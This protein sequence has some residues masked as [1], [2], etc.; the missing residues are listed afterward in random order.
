MNKYNIH[1]NNKHVEKRILLVDNDKNFTESLYDILELH[2]YTLEVAY[3]ITDA[4]KIVKNFNAH[5]ALLDL[6]MPDWPGTTLLSKLMKENQERICII[7]TGNADVDSA[8]SAMK[9]D[10]FYYLQK[11]VQP[12]ALINLL[13]RAFEK[14]RFQDEKRLTGISLQ[15]ES[16]ECFRL[17]FENAL[18]AI[19]WTDVTTDLII[20][21][22]IAAESLLEKEK[23]NIVGYHQSLVFPPEKAEYYLD[24]FKRQLEEKGI[25]DSETEVITQ[26]GKRKPVRI[27]AST[28]RIGKR[29]IIQSIIRDITERK[30]AESELRESEIKYRRLIEGLQ[31]NYFF[32]AYNSEGIFTYISPSVKNVLGYSPEEFLTHY[33]KYLTDNPLNNAMKRHTE[34]CLKGVKQPPY[35]AE[36][37]HKNG[38]LRILQAQDIPIFDTKNI[39]VEVKGIAKDITMQKLTEKVLV[40][41]ARDAVLIAEVGVAL[42]SNNTLQKTLQTCC[43]SIVKNLDAAFTRIWTFNENKH[44][45]ELQ[46]SSGMYTHIDGFHSSVPVGNLM[47]GLIAENRQPILTNSVTSDVRIKDK[48]WAKREGI[49]SF[50]GYPLL[51]DDRLMGVLALFSRNYLQKTILNTLGSIAVGIALGMK[52]IRTEDSLKTRIEF[53]GMVSRISTR[54]VKFSDF[55]KAINVSLSDVGKLCNASRV[56]LFRLLENGKY[57]DNTHEWCNA[58]VAP[59]TKY[60]KNIPSSS[61]PWLLK[62]LYAGKTIHIPDVSKIS[63]EA[64]VEKE[65][66]MKKGIKSLLIFPVYTGKELFGFIGFDSLEINIAWDEEDI[67]LLRIT[68]E[69]I[70]SAI[71]RNQNE[72][73]LRKLSQAVEQSPSTTIITDTTGTIEYVNKKFSES[74][75]Y[76]YEEVVGK[77]PRILK[78][79]NMPLTEYKYLWKTILSGMEWHGEFHNRKKNGE[80]YWEQAHISPIKNSQGINTHFLAIKED[81]TERKKF[82][83]QLLF[84]ADHDPLTNLF[85]RRR[86][87]IELEH[88]LAQSKRYNTNG[89]LMFL[90]LDNFKYYNDTHGHQ[91]GDELLV[92]LSN[93]LTERIRGTDIISRLGGDEFAIILPFTDVEKAYSISSQILQLVRGFFSTKENKSFYLT[94]SIGIV[95]YPEHGNELETLLTY[96]DMAMY[97]AKEKGRNQICVFSPE[98]KMQIEVR[99]TWEKRIRHSLEHNKFILYLQPIV[100]LRNDVICGY[101]TLLRMIGDN[102]E[103]ILPK[104]FLDIAER[105]GLIRDI[106]RWVVRQAIQLIANH[107]LDARNI[108]LEVNLSGKAFTDNELLSIIKYEL[109]TK[110]VNPEYLIF[111]ITETATI[112]NIAVA[113][114]FIS[115]LKGIGCRFALDDFGVGFSTFSYLKHLPVDFLKIDGSFI[116]ELSHNLADQHLVKAMVEVATGLKKQ[117]I[118][119]YV[120]NKETLNLLKTFGVAYAQ[121]NYIGPPATIPDALR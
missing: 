95:A 94:V 121:G 44:L 60:L 52:R 7:I 88:I 76:A 103:H 13:D 31:Y 75:G 15:E 71:T 74:T 57:I 100:D 9:K 116:G 36:V 51:V 30:K 5:V 18:D 111:E 33:S 115:T 21:C 47:V 96:A 119:E 72:E 68:S 83:T 78:S 89:A 24:I 93:V 14:I 41:R 28:T 32:Y 92:K 84:F 37:Y 66:F 97:K 120:D 105:F 48:E 19:I 39:V 55:N 43:D 22:N 62:N 49:T 110:G 114:D 117:T 77:N 70:G 109:T 29:V 11:P 46:A 6:K 16:E 53:E 50:T 69:I 104:D 2:G 63:P 67:A 86:F 107:T 79:G 23:A 108:L 106:D 91:K 61:Y 99:L 1:T 3:S 81:I 80:L 27:T 73:Q 82:E 25:L 56:Y 87:R 34:L 58:G 45:L 40:Q 26:S 8:I 59:D 54:F 17:T 64:L 113:Q 102:G 38:S 35:E 90:D 42:T 85:N 20:K 101:E 65:I 98:H 118:A 12:A 4:T 10:V 112:E